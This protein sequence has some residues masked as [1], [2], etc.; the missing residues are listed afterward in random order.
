MM[1]RDL[2][3]LE[4]LSL[5]RIQPYARFKLFRGIPKLTCPTRL[6]A[7]QKKDAELYIMIMNSQEA[8]MTCPLRIYFNSES[9]HPYQ[10]GV[11]RTSKVKPLIK[12]LLNN[13]N[14]YKEFR[15]PLH[16][17]TQYI[18]TGDTVTEGDQDDFHDE[19]T[20]K[21][22]YLLNQ[23]PNQNAAVFLTEQ[24]NNHLSNNYIRMESRGIRRFIAESTSC[25]TKAESI[26]AVLHDDDDVERAAF[27]YLYPEGNS[28]STQRPSLKHPLKDCAPWKFWKYAQAQLKSDHITDPLFTFTL[29]QE[30]I[31]RRIINSFYT[32]VQKGS[33]T[34][35]D[36]T[37]FRQMVMQSSPQD[38]CRHKAIKRLTRHFPPLPSYFW[39]QRYQLETIMACHGPPQLFITCSTDEEMIIRSHPWI[40]KRFL[41][42]I[43]TH[44]WNC[45]TVIRQNW[46]FFAEFMADYWI[47]LIKN[48]KKKLGESG[49]PV[50]ATWHRLEFQQRGTEHIHLLIW[51]Q[52][53]WLPF[54]WAITNGQE[55]L[56]QQIA[57][58]E[59]LANTL[60]TTEGKG[61]QL[62]S[63]GNR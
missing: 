19:N 52:N 29:F 55:C 61:S 22:V 28:P 43:F 25:K 16:D 54:E 36:S 40:L 39:H 6:K 42:K 11:V 37:S 57:Q 1:F 17:D 7:I 44:E 58:V 47:I 33:W 8:N 56:Q 31:V 13:N 63:H 30:T 4:R 21:S 60:I 12:Y 9:I 2:R 34:A 23:D 10:K 62:H 46:G 45:Q 3:D 14:Y 18:D 32:A 15:S 27:V 59:N 49:C 38:V 51:L 35:D 5:C 26:A 41:T 24:T 20:H 50:K 48:I 53:P